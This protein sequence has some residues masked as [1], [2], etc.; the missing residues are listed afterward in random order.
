VTDTGVVDLLPG[1]ATRRAAKNALAVSVAQVLG[2]VATLAAT[3]AAA[4]ELGPLQF[5]TFAYAISFAL[6]VAT[7]PSWGFDP[8]L[9]QRGSKDPKSI[10]RLLSETLAWRTAIAVP[11]FVG[12]AIASLVLRPD[13]E[14]AWVFVIVLVATAVEIYADAGH[15][16]AAALQNQV[17]T[18]A[19][20]VA[21]RFVTAALTIASL[22]LGYGLVG[23]A[24]AYL[25]GSVIGAVGVAGAVRRL[26]VRLDLR[27]V[28]RK[29]M[30]DTL[31]MSI[32]IGIDTVI[33]LAL[34]RID[35]VMLGALKNDA[36][37]GI[38]AAAYRLLETVLFVSWAV[39]KA[40][41]PVM[42]AS[43]EP[44]RVRRGVEQGLA[45]I[46]LL[47]IPFGVGLA[48]E[49]GPVMDLLYG[50]AYA[51]HGT[52][53]AQWLAPAPLLFAAAYLG[54]YALLARER[55]WKVVAMSLAALVVNVGLNFALIPPYGVTGA[56]AATTLS[57]LV[58]A[59]VA[60]TFLAP[61]I[62]IPNLLRGLAPAL[63]A[64]GCMAVV[65]LAV[66]AGLAVEIPLGV[67]VFTGVW[68][69]L[70]RWW[71]PEQLG[72]IRSFLPGGGGRTSEDAEPRE[73]ADVG[74]PDS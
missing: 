9:T 47:Y 27:S 40:V 68:L 8:L 64:S 21:Q 14:S 10:P 52:L 62:G 51:L 54:S 55:R 36:A 32:A 6:L 18:S 66:D 31:R 58:E 23:L 15:A 11:V 3:I 38:Y 48:I 42:S 7:L 1:P 67:V 73:D 37:V 26:G 57:Y 16:T 46:G 17:W 34:F 39:A 49:A 74:S 20:L 53:A 72:V 25:V 56:A 69:P 71:T 44:W 59:V 2:K 22:V 30:R 61:D 4:R 5:G 29:G 65:L 24:V 13:A 50:P 19:W 43:T 41:F 28:H 35:Q 12:A 45:A 60:L 70:A 33:S 63:V